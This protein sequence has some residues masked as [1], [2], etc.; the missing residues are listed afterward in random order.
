MSGIPTVSALDMI[1]ELQNHTIFAFSDIEAHKQDLQSMRQYLETEARQRLDTLLASHDAVLLFI[2]AGCFL[3]YKLALECYDPGSRRLTEKEKMRV[4]KAYLCCNQYWTDKTSKNLNTKDLVGIYIRSDLPIVEFKLHKDF[5]VQIYKAKEFFNFCEQDELFKPFLTW[6]Y[7]DHKVKD[8]KEYLLNWLN[9]LYCTLNNRWISLEE[10]KS[11]IEIAFFDQ[12]AACPSDCGE[13][14]RHDDQYYLRNHMLYSPQRGLYLLLNH[15]LMVDKFY[16]GMKMDFADTVL[17]HSGLNDNGKLIKDKRDFNSLV[18]SRISESKLFYSL[19]HKSFDGHYD[20]ICEGD[21]MKP[22]FNNEAEPDFYLRR[23]SHIFLFEY[24]DITLGDSVKYSDDIE[25]IK[26]EIVRRICKGSCSDR[27]GGGQLLY[28]INAIVNEKKM[29]ELDAEAEK[30]DIIFPI[31][32]TT[33]RA[34]SAMGINYLIIPEFAK[35][36]GEYELNSAQIA[37]VVIFDY[38]VLFMLCNQL[39]EGVLD[40]ENILTEYAKKLLNSPNGIDFISSFYTFAYDSYRLEEK[41]EEQLQYVIGD[42]FNEI[43]DN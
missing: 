27:K 18:G 40:L 31:I 14:W 22:I 43:K 23:G 8:W 24:K 6:F 41:T 3:F 32:V 21:A 15:N 16:Q 39:H 29:R 5:L 1:V 12:Y 36:A 10:K 9:F 35:L 26:K 20:V 42:L 38:D 37:P 19:M 17:C 34:F 4:Y 13:L 11:A 25:Y 30:A 28:S 33:D 7:E 2:T